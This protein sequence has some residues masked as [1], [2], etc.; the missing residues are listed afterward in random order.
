MNLNNVSWQRYRFESC[1]L[2]IS[3]CQVPKQEIEAHDEE[4]SKSLVSTV[5]NS[6]VYLK[7]AKSIVMKELKPFTFDNM[8]I[9]AYTKEEAQYLFLTIKY[10]TN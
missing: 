8:C 1:F 10:K 3:S 9:W 2:Y 6:V 7:V 4:S 5:S